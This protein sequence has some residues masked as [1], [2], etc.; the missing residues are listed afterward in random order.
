VRSADRVPRPPCLRQ[1]RTTGLVRERRPDD[2]SDEVDGERDHDEQQHDAD[3]ADELVLPRAEGHGA[4][5]APWTMVFRK[6][7][8]VRRSVRG[9]HVAA[10]AVVGTVDLHQSLR[11]L[12]L[13]AVALEVEPG[14]DPRQRIARIVDALKPACWRQVTH[15]ASSAGP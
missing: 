8:W 2:R 9:A 12:D 3:A 1:L 13:R 11:S 4:A 7:R 14:L 6:A 5:P 10:C 15:P